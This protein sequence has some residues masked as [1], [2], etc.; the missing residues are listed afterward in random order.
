V[1]LTLTREQVA[2]SLRL[3]KTRRDSLLHDDVATFE[4]QLERFL[5]FCANDLLAR[6]VPGTLNGRSVEPA[7]GYRVDYQGHSVVISGDTKPS[8][9]LVKF[10]Q[11]V[12]VLI[13]ELGQ[14]KQGGAD[15]PARRIDP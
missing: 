7:F 1:E 5:E 4:H 10:S 12:D 13:H 6:N 3:F 11:H 8:E 14:S 9:S 15:W 2:N